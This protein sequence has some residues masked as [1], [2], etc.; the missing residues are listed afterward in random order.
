MAF[1]R[2][3]S[4]QLR[5]D[6]VDQKYYIYISEYKMLYENYALRMTPPSLMAFLIVKK[7]IY[8][9]YENNCSSGTIEVNPF[10]YISPFVEM[11]AHACIE[12]VLF[13]L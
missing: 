12:V 3:C 9:Y 11:N 1:T 4:I 2:Y 13:V 6:A 10:L 5:N 8:W 7:K